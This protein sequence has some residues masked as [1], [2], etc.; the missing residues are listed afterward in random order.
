VL[1][2][3]F[4]SAGASAVVPGDHPHDLQRHPRVDQTAEDAGATDGETLHVVA[5]MFAV[6]DGADEPPQHITDQPRGDDGQQR[7]P[8]GLVKNQRKSVFLAAGGIALFDSGTHGEAAHDH[9]HDAD[10]CVAESRQALNHEH[11][12]RTK[13]AIGVKAAQ[14]VQCCRRKSEKAR[15]LAKKREKPIA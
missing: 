9:V 13:R 7:A 11:A 5:A 3:L 12:C 14:L 15:I 8:E 4:A 10:G 6:S 2:L 1:R